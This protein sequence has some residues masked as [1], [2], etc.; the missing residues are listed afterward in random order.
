MSRSKKVIT[1]KKEHG[2][3]L[4]ALLI[5]IAL[6][7]ILYSVLILYLRADQNEPSPAWIWILLFGLTLAD[8]VA[9]YAIWKWKKWGLQ[10][11]AVSVVASIVVGLML[12]GSQ[13]IVF[14]D[15]MPLVFLG[16]LIKDRWSLFE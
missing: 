9:V 5:F 8:I 3:W 2:V 13:L 15:I 11:Y 4:K 16:Y 1:K 12:T 14:H 7:S 10:L 6:Q